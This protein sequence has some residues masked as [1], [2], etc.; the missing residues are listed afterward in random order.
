MQEVYIAIE[1]TMSEC[2]KDWMHSISKDQT[3]C[4]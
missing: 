4:K 1:I 3:R 2:E